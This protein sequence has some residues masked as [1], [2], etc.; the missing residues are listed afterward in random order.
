[1]EARGGAVTFVAKVL[2]AGWKRAGIRNDA[3]A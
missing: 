3:A 1:M 2:D